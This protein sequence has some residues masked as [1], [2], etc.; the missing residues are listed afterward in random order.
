MDRNSSHTDNSPSFPGETDFYTLLGDGDVGGKAKGLISTGEHL[1]PHFKENPIGNIRFEIPRFTVITTSFYDTFITHNNLEN[2]VFSDMSDERIAHHF[3]NGHLPVTLNRELMD[4]IG[5]TSSPLAVR[6]SSLMEDALDSPFAGTYKTKMIPNHQPDPDKRFHQ[7]SEA[8][9]YVY[10]STFFRDARSYRQSIGIKDSDEKMAVIIQEIAGAHHN[11][12]YYPNIA[13]VA[14]SFNFYPVGNARPEDGVVHLALGLGKTI[15][16]GGYSWHFSPAYPKVQPPYNSPKDLLN[17][18]QTRFWAVNIGK[19]PPYDPVRE[20]EH[21]IQLDLA[22]AEYDDTISLIASTY[23][24]PSDLIRMGTGNQGPRVITFAPILDLELL[25]LN[26]FI[27]IFMSQCEKLLKNRVEIEFAVTLGSKS[28]DG[29]TFSFLQVRP[30]KEL[31]PVS[32]DLATIPG[33]DCL[34]YSEN[35]MGNGEI[36]DIE[37]IL[38]VDPDTFDLSQSR[39]IAG[40]IEYLNQIMLKQKKPYLLMGFGRWGS[41]DP[42]LGIPVSWGQISGARSIV[43]SSLSERSIDMSQGSHFFH[44]MTSL[45]I[46]YFSMDN[47]KNSRI[48]WN[49]LK[50]RQVMNKTNYCKLLQTPS[51]LHVIADG[52]KRTGVILK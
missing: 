35:V 3:L 17:N 14:K 40:E 2:L 6:S 34:L 45:S 25:P 41:S 38:M 51:P 21:M 9:K 18:S 50:E 28:S 13:G 47:S 42:W 46:I 1:L 36:N 24:G 31:T 15:V 52:I 44:N 48:D 26:Q 22:E 11:R 29:A 19:P 7:L 30:L 27:K 39:E 20:T 32:T 12:R 33:A 16:D 37:T 43:E 23:D 4:L 49:W 10:A 5:N 8:V